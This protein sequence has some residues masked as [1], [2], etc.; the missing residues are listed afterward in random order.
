[1]KNFF[2]VK[3]VIISLLL[4][5]GCSS[6][7]TIGDNNAVEIKQ[8]EDSVKSGT[9]RVTSYIDS[10]KNETNDYAGYNFTFN[11]NGSL[12][13]F[14]G[15]N[16]VNGTWSVTDHSSSSN[17]DSNDDDDFDFNILFSAP[18]NFEELSDDWD[19]MSISNT[20]MELIDVSGGSGETDSLSFTKN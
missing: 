6:D 11:E 8:I 17:D 19:I 1:M 2:K 4:L 13:A 15:T 7:D 18:P 16:V 12:V 14:N 20:K 5:I 10:G 3:F 9:W